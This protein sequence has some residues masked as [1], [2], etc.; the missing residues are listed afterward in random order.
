M[1]TGGSKGKG[2]TSRK[3]DEG[4]GQAG[5]RSGGVEAHGLG[6]GLAGGQ[7]RQLLQPLLQ[8]QWEL[9]IASLTHRLHVKLHKLV[10]GEEVQQSGEPQAPP[11]Q[12]TAVQVPG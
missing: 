3:G 7:L 4:G 10:P 12:P 2:A 6:V 8:L 11:T 5:A 1:R 9:L